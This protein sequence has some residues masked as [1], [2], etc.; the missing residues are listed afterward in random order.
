MTEDEQ[1][2]VTI[3]W[4]GMLLILA[5]LVFMVWFVWQLLTTPI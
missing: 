5:Y 2:V 1:V 3:E 4:W